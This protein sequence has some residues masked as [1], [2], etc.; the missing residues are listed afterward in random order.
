MAPC[1]LPFL[2]A[3]DVATSRWPADSSAGSP[4]AD[5]GDEHYQSAVGSAT[6]PWRILPKHCGW[7]DERGKIYGQANPPSQ[8]WETFL[9]NEADGIAAARRPLWK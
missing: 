7:T 6:D 9:R 1:G 5:P 4:P 3:L 8:E 2:L